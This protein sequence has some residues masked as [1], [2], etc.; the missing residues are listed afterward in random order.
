MFHLSGGLKPK[1]TSLEKLI[2]FERKT[3]QLSQNTNI[4]KN[5]EITKQKKKKKKKKTTTT[6]K[7]LIFFSWTITKV[8]YL[9]YVL[10]HQFALQM[11]TVVVFG[12]H[13]Y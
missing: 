6:I 13:D 10:V 8:A 11:V 5:F 12:F 2:G 1:S 4:C 9:P 7:L 3:G